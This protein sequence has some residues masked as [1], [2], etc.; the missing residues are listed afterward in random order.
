MPRLNYKNLYRLMSDTLSHKGDTHTV[1]VHSLVDPSTMWSFSIIALGIHRVRIAS[2]LSQMQ[3][4]MM[5]SMDKDGMPWFN[6]MRSHDGVM[7]GDLEEA[8][9]LLAIGRAAGM[10]R[11][12]TPRSDCDV[13][14]AVILDDDVR[15]MERCRP[16]EKRNRSMLY[17]K[18]NYKK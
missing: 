9:K 3:V 13:P 17:W 10:V 2:L 15:Y 1:E 5:Q 4:P 7:W 12:H 6:A 16:E 8:D 14:Y 11:T 18:F